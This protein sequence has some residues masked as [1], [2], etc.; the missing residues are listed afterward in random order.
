MAEITVDMLT[1][2]MA[3]LR[4]GYPSHYVMVYSG[5]DLVAFPIPVMALAG[6]IIDG[7]VMQ[8]RY[9]GRLVLTE[10]AEAWLRKEGAIP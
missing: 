8:N 7:I 3:S 5:D 1:R 6:A 4:R 9:T 2:M 10:A